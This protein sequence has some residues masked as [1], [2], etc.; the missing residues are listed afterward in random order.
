MCA[1]GMDILQVLGLLVVQLAEHPLVQHLGEADD[2]VERGAQLVRHIGQE[3]RLVA[4]GGLELPALVRDLPEEPGVLDRQ[5]RLGGEGL[6]YVYDF[7]R[8]LTGRLPREGQ[9]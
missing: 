4:A 3:L 8:E 1:R 6:Q 2:R 7:W 9:A 5:G